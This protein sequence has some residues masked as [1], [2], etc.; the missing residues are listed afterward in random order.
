VGGGRSLRFLQGAGVGG[1]EPLGGA[2]VYRCDLGA[3]FRR[4]YRLRK[5]LGFRLCFEGARL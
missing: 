1:L 2:A 5:K 4:L 3:Q